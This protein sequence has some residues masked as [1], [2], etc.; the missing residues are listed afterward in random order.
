MPVKLVSEMVGN[1]SVARQGHAAF[2]VDDCRILICGGFTATRSAHRRYTPKATAFWNTETNAEEPSPDMK[3]ARFAGSFTRLPGGKIVAVGGVEQDGSVVRYNRNVEIYDHQLGRW[4]QAPIEVSPRAF[5]SATALDETRVLIVG[6][7]SGTSLVQAR[8]RMDIEILDTEKWTIET[9]GDLE[10]PREHSSIATRHDH[11]R[12][13]FGGF[14][15]DCQ[16]ANSTFFDI[17]HLDGSISSTTSPGLPSRKWSGT[18]QVQD[19]IWMTGGIVSMS[20]YRASWMKNF[21]FSTQS[22]KWTEVQPLQSIRIKHL[23]VPVHLGVAAIGGWTPNDA[24]SAKVEYIS[25]LPGVSTICGELLIPRWSH[26]VSAIGDGRF[27]V[28]GGCSQNASISNIERLSFTV[29]SP[30]TASSYS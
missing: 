28:I 20:S 7:R 19:Q 13:L 21:V 12:L 25:A 2:L 15:V 9:I 16:S 27:I 29:Y 18:I 3:S 30:V 23:L 1:L 4:E 14:T 11:A 24:D 5:H 26:S 17:I 10:H 6:G 22:E 8:H